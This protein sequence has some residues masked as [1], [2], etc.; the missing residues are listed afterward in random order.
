M[1]FERIYYLRRENNMT[2]EELAEKSGVSRQAIQKWETGQ[3]V[4]TIDN[5]VK[6]SEL[7]NVTLDYLCK[8]I[9]GDNAR[10]DTEKKY[11]LNYEK[12]V[13]AYFGTLDI[14]YA[15]CFDEGKDVAQ[16]KELFMSV[17]KMPNDEY[18]GRIADVIFDMVN[19]LSQ[20]AD[21]D[22]FEPNDLTTIRLQREKTEKI[23]GFERSLLSDKMKGGWYGRICGCLLGKPVELMVFNE[24]EKV[25]KRT[26]NY[27]IYRYITAE[28]VADIDTD[29][30][31]FPIKVC[32]YSKNLGVMLSDDDTNYMLIAYETL[33]RHG[34]DFTSDDIAEVWTTT[35]TYNAY[36]S[37][38]YIAYTNIIA[39][40]TPP[41]SGE[42]KNA[43]REWVG[44]QIRG[45]VWGYVNPG[46]TEKAAEMA[47]RDAR[48]SHV[49]NGIYGEMWVS[50][51][52]AAAYTT[53]D[54]K[55]IIKAG[56]GEIPRSSRLHKA[57]NGIIGKYESG[58]SA[59]ECFA[60]IRS[61]WNEKFKHH[62]CHVISNAEIVAA[63]LLYG[64][65]DYGKSI[66]LAVG[67]AFDTD[68]NGAT[69][70]SV[71]GVALGFEKLPK[72]WVDQINDTLISTLSGYEKVSVK[73][74]AE[75]TLGYIG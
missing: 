41:A 24:L 73:D 58:M 5:L 35:Q 38:E 62:W 3:S 27:P 43:Y 32:A 6:L 44:A 51:M 29:D 61:R 30:I 52:I 1:V 42:Y 47:W 75:K 48:V 7:F 10:V 22:F 23:D 21:F 68:C 17:K 25:L 59:D 33:K 69:V 31:S 18:K 71:L 40:Y 28:E 20:R 34:R 57:I 49:K 16:Y 72:V 54:I 37:A 13:G 53:R 4:P 36:C 14:E 60:D 55:T 2:Q 15:Q 64:E 56:L 70:G 45:D 67:T 74:I 39:G 63:A 26:N 65:G 8:D 50:A 19:R 11:K 46:N 66:C 9:A 12:Y